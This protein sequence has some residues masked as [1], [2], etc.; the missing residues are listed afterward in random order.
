M[1]TGEGSPFKV[2]V[3][4]KVEKKIVQPEDVSGQVERL[5]RYHQGPDVGEWGDRSARALASVE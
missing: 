3:D 2:G 5:A 1:A 4:Y